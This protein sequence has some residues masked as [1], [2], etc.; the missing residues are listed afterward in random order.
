[1]PSGFL[2]AVL[3]SSRRSRLACRSPFYFLVSLLQLFIRSALNYC[4]A[5]RATAL[6]EKHRRLSPAGLLSGGAKKHQYDDEA[7]RYAQ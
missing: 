4:E 7:D 5:K 6:N 1:L 3:P 2:D